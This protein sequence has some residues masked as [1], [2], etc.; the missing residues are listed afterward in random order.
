VNADGA[1]ARIFPAVE[2]SNKALTFNVLT[3]VREIT[4]NSIDSKRK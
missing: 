3:S 1:D 4:S 2:T